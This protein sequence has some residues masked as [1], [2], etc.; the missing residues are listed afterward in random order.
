MPL[1]THIFRIQSHFIHLLSILLILLCSIHSSH[2]SG[3]QQYQ[4]NSYTYQISATPD[5][6]TDVPLNRKVAETMLMGAASRYLIYDLQTK[7]FIDQTH[8]DYTH[9]AIQPLNQ[10]GVEDNAEIEISFNP[11]YQ[12]LAI[13]KI[14]L[15]R[16]GQIIDQIKPDNIKLLQ[17]ETDLENRILDGRVTAY[18]ILNDVQVDDIIEYQY[19]ITG[20]NPVYQNHFF[21]RYPTAWGVSVDKLYTKVILPKKI[22]I[23]P[24]TFNTTLK[25]KRTTQGQY[26]IFEWQQNQTPEMDY[27]DQTPKWY[28]NYPFIQLSEFKNW[29]E[30]KRWAETL[31]PTKMPPLNEQLEKKLQEWSALPK[32]AQISSALQ[33][34]QDN[35]RYLGVEIGVNSHKPTLPNEVIKQGFG[36]C[37]DKSLLL[38]TLLKQMGFNAYSALVS[39]NLHRGIETLPPTPGAFD[40]VIAMVEYNGQ[41]YWLD[42]T[43]TYQAGRLD[44]RSVSDF[45]YA[46]L[47][48][49]PEQ[50]LTKVESHYSSEPSI[51]VLE[52]FEPQ[53]FQEDGDVYLTVTTTYTH[54]YAEYYRYYFATTP[55]RD[56][57]KKFINYYA[58]YYPR[59]MQVDSL[60]VSDNTQ[61]NQLSILERYKIN[62]FWSFGKKDKDVMYYL[63]KGH[64]LNSYLKKPEILRRTMPLALVY[65][66]N[67]THEIEINY[68]KA[69]APTIEH[70][71]VHFENSGFD[72]QRQF[73]FEPQRDAATFKLQFKQD[74][75]SAKALPEYLE[76]LDEISEDLNFNYGVKPSVI[77]ELRPIDLLRFRLK[78]LN[79]KFH[80]PSDTTAGE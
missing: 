4:S 36:D 53:D 47:I 80:Q 54:Q 48:H 58:Q 34:V 3:A 73:I 75:V 8:I 19:S 61:L 1:F 50:Q 59:I 66:L 13:H 67:V 11:E 30:V 6:V 9:A 5:W 68:P 23:S 79:A 46:L 2:A 77:K 52:T 17:K 10:T 35:I 25:P 72:Y 69:I 78:Q 20:Q 63:T 71:S 44:G 65:P 29:A 18:I 42:P 12:Q 55:K 64:T 43:R 41:R 7:R 26:Q 24:Q 70:K 16:K 21:E 32:A 62:D 27:E 37:K 60:Q 76:Q 28:I 38:V 51:H 14:V 45:G 33:F 49:H 74:H 31:Y 57:E 56:I 15:H 39:H 22:A 40:H